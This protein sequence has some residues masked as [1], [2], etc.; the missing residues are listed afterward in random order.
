VFSTGDEL[1]E[2]GV[3]L[4]AGGIHDSNRVML[5]A[6]LRGLGAVVTDLGILPDRHTA[7]AEALAAAAPVHD[8][9]VTSGGVSTGEED[10]V[11][12][13]VA[14]MGSLFFWRLAIKPGRPVA[15]GHVGGTAF[16]GLP[17]NP[18]AVMT[19]FLHVLRP[20]ALLLAG[21]RAEPPLRM[22]VR[23]GFAYRKKPGRLEYVR[24]M[25]RVAEGGLVAEKF[26]REGAGLLSSLAQTDGLVELGLD[27]TGVAP[28]D[29]VPF[30]PWKAM[31]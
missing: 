13:A 17:G 12:A 22:P 4:P 1:A 26:P 15:L 16:A 25:L 30:L 2:P 31:L 11:K 6:L 14:A 18:A 29:A 9:L 10:H 7:I 19:T 3:A 23:A 20:I 28:G 8:L 24:A 5:T 27:A 21:A